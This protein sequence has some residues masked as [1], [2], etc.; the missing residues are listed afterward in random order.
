MDNNIIY[1]EDCITGL[2]K[3]DTNSVDGCITDPPYNYEFIGHKWNNEEI[4]RRVSRV[5]NSSTLVKHI[6]YGSGLSGGKRDANWYRKNRKNIL[7]YGKWVE[8]WA[9]EV[10]RVLKPGAFCLVFN[11]SRT[12][13]HVQIAL[14][15]VGFY[16][17]DILVY[18]KNSGIPKG[19]NISKKLEKLGIDNFQDWSGWHSCLRNEWE[20]IVL[21]QKPLL[22]NHIETLEKYEIGLLKATHSEGF[23]SNIIDSVKRDKK[24]D[25]NNHT[26]V[27]PVELIYKLIELTIPKR[28]SKIVLDP[29]MGSGTLAIAAIKYGVSYIGFEISSDY[30]NIIK[31]RID[32]LQNNLF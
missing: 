3:L 2:K 31:K 27:K 26:T 5:Q 14:E 18:K 17:K 9:V 28:V 6:P 23:L 8:K 1:N 7:D 19:I 29:F 24:D 16:T 21:V 30:C 25:F 20:S 15:N 4:E 13:A 10:Y 22:N 12:I 11:S 32:N